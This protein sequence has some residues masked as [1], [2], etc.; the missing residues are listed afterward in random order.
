MYDKYTVIYRYMR[1]IQIDRQRDDYNRNFK[2][3]TT[4]RGE[5]SI[6][7]ETELWKI[8]RIKHKEAKKWNI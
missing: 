1:S 5:K 3:Q 7:W 2:W 8:A 6:N 4:Y